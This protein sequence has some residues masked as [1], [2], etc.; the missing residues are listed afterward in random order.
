M[1]NV[2]RLPQTNKIET[3]KELVQ[4]LYSTE[5]A[6]DAAMLEANRLM[7]SMIEARQELALP[8]TFG[9]EALARVA[10]TIGELSQASGELTTAHKELDD[11]RKR[12]GFRAAMIGV[13]DKPEDGEVPR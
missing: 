8:A 9:S 2:A 3:A 7:Q 13:H 11:L 5:A 12:M 6:L 4:S 10:A 1:Q